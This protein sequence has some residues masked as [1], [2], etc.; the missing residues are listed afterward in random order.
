MNDVPK[1]E[2]ISQGASCRS[3]AEL[4]QN[5]SRSMHRAM[6]DF[7]DRHRD[8][9]LQLAAQAL[10]DRLCQGHLQKSP[11]LFFEDL[12]EVTMS[13]FEKRLY[14][15][16]LQKMEGELAEKLARASQIFSAP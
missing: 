5:D 14:N 13:L 9:L 11:N 12:L 3:V 7:F 2:E 10:V 16:L 15:G 6:E 4:F 8:E 1:S